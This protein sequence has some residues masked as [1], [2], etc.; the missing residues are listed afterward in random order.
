[1]IICPAGKLILSMN[2]GRKPEHGLLYALGMLTA[3]GAWARDHKFMQQ[4]GRLCGQDGA[5]RAARISLYVFTPSCSHDIA[6]GFGNF[7]VNPFLRNCWR[8]T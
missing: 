7:L 1:M 8:R 3:A 5:L 2:T 6:I 4:S